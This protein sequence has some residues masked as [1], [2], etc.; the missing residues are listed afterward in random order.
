[1]MCDVM[2]QLF[3]LSYW[4]V[5]PL[6]KSLVFQLF[7][8]YLLC[9]KQSTQLMQSLPKSQRHFF[10]ETEKSTLKFTW[11]LKGPQKA[12]KFLQKNNVAQVTSVAYH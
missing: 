11:N 9:I 4:I 10:A 12:K 6:Y 8:P 3:S 2:D 7:N 1:M 5:S